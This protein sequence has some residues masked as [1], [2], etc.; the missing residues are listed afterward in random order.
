MNALLALLVGL[1]MR[2]GVPW[3]EPVP[4]PGPKP[5]PKP[6]PA[7]APKPAPKTVPAPKAVPTAPAPK[8]APKR[9]T[10]PTGTLQTKPPPFTEWPQVPA[11]DLPPFPAGWEPD[12]PVPPAEVA[13]AKVLL[14]ILWKKGLGTTVVEQTAGKW[15]T[16]LAFIPAKGKKG[17]SAWRVKATA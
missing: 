7:P 4:K 6:E 9:A 3:L 2:M 10:A 13:R 5:A 17:V 11:S 15:V 1:L 8:T 16:Y 12:V 14:P